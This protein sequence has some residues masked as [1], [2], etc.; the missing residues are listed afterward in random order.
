VTSSSKVV[1]GSV[2][3]LALAAVALVVLA[4]R[5]TRPEESE[6]PPERSEAPERGAGSVVPRSPAVPPES[7][8]VAPSDEAKR[9]GPAGIVET[10]S[11]SRD[12]R[13]LEAALRAVL[14]T[15]SSRSTRKPAPDAALEAALVRHF[16]AEDGAVAR[17]AFAAA[18]VPLMSEPPSAEL[19]SAVAGT[20]AP[21]EPAARRVLA[22]DA[23]NLIRP[24]RRS[25]PVLAAIQRSLAAPEP[26]VV[27]QALFALA[28]SG[29]SLPA[30]SDA[31]RAELGVRVLEL[32]RH[33]N[34]AVRGRA[35]FVLAELAE[36]V[37][38]EVRLRAAIAHLDDPEPYVRAEAASLAGKTR[39]PGAIHALMAR[40]E[41]LAVARFDLAYVDVEGARSIAEHRVPGREHVAEAALFSILA[42]S[43]LLPGAPSLELTLGTSARE[44][45]VRENAAIARA[46]YRQSAAQIPR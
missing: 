36:L 1:V 18:R 21:D 28:H 15:Y 26:E 35:L 17:A 6:R 16:R 41:D 3:A 27:S 14:S 9:A 29:P 19:A 38:A 13:A 25:P 23:L 20:I 39:A 7:P 11:T 45:G 43:R 12:P 10:L 42:L 8:R 24:D 31:S 22:L 40:V 30:L 44:A 33:S 46:W 34:G 5:G 32:A 4:A 2:L 37:A